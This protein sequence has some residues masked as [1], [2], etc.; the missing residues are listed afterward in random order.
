MSLT[1]RTR[2]PAIPETT[3]AMM[4]RAQKHNHARTVRDKAKKIGTSGSSSM[5][6]NRLKLKMSK[7]RSMT[8]P[9][10]KTKTKTKT[11]TKRPLITLITLS[12]LPLCSPAPLLM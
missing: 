3:F 9:K 6:L 7:K 4:T 2:S 8:K 12:P 1:T 5:L 11:K 10:P